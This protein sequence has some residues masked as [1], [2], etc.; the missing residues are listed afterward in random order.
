MTI[1]QDGRLKGIDFLRGLAVLLMVQQHLIAWLW[2]IPWSST[3]DILDMKAHMLIL[4]AMGGIAAP[5]FVTLAGFGFIFLVNKVVYNDKKILIRGVVLLASGYLMNI[6][7]PSWFSGGSWYVL[8]MIGAAF[9]LSPLLRRLPLNVLIGLVFLI[10]FT[11]PL[12]QN[13]LQTPFYLHNARMGQYSLKGFIFR[14]AFVEGHFPV[15]PWLGFYISGMIAA[16]WY[17]ENKLKKIVYFALTLGVLS[18]ILAALNL[19]QV[20]TSGFLLRFVKVLTRFYPPLPPMIFL[21]MGG[22]LVITAI[23]LFFCDMKDKISQSNAM[24]KLG[25]IS[26]T[27][28]LFHAIIF[29]ELFI[30]INLHRS[31]N[32]WVTLIIIYI[33]I[34]VLI[35]ISHFWSKISYKGS[36]EWFMR[37]LSSKV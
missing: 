6:L 29:R 18:G 15:F 21:L 27:V 22:A 36:I 2:K 16:L 35:L 14:L 11:A 7:I 34:I 19:G 5:L 17:K 13:I 1:P 31:F 10:V 24:I 20:I 4:N 12:L 23:S 9:L 32:E 26:L 25:R 3:S 33:F 37:W 30:K 28:L 8:H